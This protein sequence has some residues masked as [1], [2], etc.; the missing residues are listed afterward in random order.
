MKSYSELI[1]MLLGTTIL[2]FLAGYYIAK[3]K[4]NIKNDSFIKM[5]KKRV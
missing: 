1:I 3:I 5:R 2:G 4:Y